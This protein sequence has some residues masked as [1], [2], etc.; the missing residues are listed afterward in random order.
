MSLDK[1]K[2]ETWFIHK[3]AKGFISIRSNTK[4][5]KLGKPK[6]ICYFNG[7]GGNNQVRD[8]KLIVRAVNEFMAVRASGN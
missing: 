4:L 8:A 7:N 1:T 3:N 6:A 2:Q 5:N